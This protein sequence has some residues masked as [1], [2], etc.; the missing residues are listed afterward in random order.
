MNAQAM[1]NLHKT[2]SSPKGKKA[3]GIIQTEMHAFKHGQLHSGSP[4][5]PVVTDKKQALAISLSKAR[6]GK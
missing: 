3:K 1:A 2:L 5:G 4:K 6:K